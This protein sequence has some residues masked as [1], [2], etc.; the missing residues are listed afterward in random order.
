M[1]VADNVA[2]PL[3]VRKTPRGEIAS[4]VTRALEM[5]RLEQFKDRRPAQLSGGQ[6]QRVAL[7]RALVFQPSLVLMDEPLGALDKKLREHM[8]IELKQIHEMLGVTIVY[9][10]HDQSEALTMSD[11]V[12]IFESG[13]IVQI[14]TP[15]LLYKEPAT[16][17]V[18][19]FIGENNALEGVVE[20]VIDGQCVVALPT[21]LRATALSIGDIRPGT[22]VH[23]A[24]RP[25]RIGLSAVEAGAE[26]RFRAKVDGRIYHGDHQRLLARLSSGQVLTVKIDADAAPATGDTIDICWRASECRAFPTGTAANAG[27]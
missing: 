9:V 25:E 19:S 22:P 10:T 4:R 16:A 24:V 13:A 26:N 21:G 6:Q 17:F 5:V 11:R 8:Q 20:R 15:D 18:A 27:S 1:S 12:A 2:F 14:G 23:L 7:A 3:S